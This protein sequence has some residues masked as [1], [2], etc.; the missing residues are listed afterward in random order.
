MKKR[1][2]LA[3]TAMLLVAIL[4]ATGATYAWFS[5]SDTA[6]TNV[7]MGVATGSSLEISTDNTNWVSV[8]SINTGSWLDRS[9]TDTAFPAIYK[10]NIAEGS[11][12]PT[13][14][15]EDTGEVKVQKIYF[16]SSKAGNVKLDT[17]S[18]IGAT[19]APNG[20]QI[21]D[22][23][24]IGV[25][26]AGTLKNIFAAYANTIDNGI[27]GTALSAT[28]TQTAKAVNA[29]TVIVTMTQGTDDAY[30]YGSADFYF[31]V[32]G[33]LCNNSMTNSSTHGTAA[34]KFAQ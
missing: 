5:R 7:D 27:N 34:L 6:S 28:G 16:R 30:Y 21:V 23:L 9:T 8:L 12:D 3:A 19:N 33:T 29:G 13:S 20:N 14:Y 32:E 24:R 22:T 25:K 4:A 1:S 31:W 11:M 26:D 18:T 15:A 10:A 2:L 17:T